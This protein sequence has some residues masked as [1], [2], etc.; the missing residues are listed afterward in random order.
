MAIRHHPGPGTQ[1]R[2]LSGS[3]RDHYQG[4]DAAVVLASRAVLH[5]SAG[6][7]TLEPSAD[8]RIFRVR[9]GGTQT[10][11]GAEHRRSRSL[12]RRESRDAKCDGAEGAAGVS[13]T[14]SAAASA[15]VGAADY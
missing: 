11:R 7:H 3:L 14:D 8:D 15:N 5:D 2:V 12:R 6:V 4:V 13:A 10:R 1:S 9:E